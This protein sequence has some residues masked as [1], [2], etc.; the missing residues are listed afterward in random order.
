M[1]AFC[2]LMIIALLAAAPIFLWSEENGA[3]LYDS[4]CSMC[5]GDKGVGNPPDVPK[6]AG[7]S[8]TVEQLVTYLTKGDSTKTYHKKPISD[9]KA[10]QAKAIAEYIKKLK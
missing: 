5:H 8:M 10:D 9:V 6:V 1:K 2:V 7:T 4:N 3:A